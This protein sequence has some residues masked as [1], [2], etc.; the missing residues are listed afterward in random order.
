MIHFLHGIIGEPA[1]FAGVIRRL[2]IAPQQINNPRL[3]YLEQDVSGLVATVADGARAGGRQI[4]V[5]NS[6]GCQLALRLPFRVDHFVLT[7][8]PFDYNTGIVPLRRNGIGAWVDGLYQQKGNIEGEAAFL[9]SA[10][11]MVDAFMVDRRMIGKIREFRAEAQRFLASP[12]LQARSADVTFLIG[13]Q[14][15]STPP[16]DFANFVATTVPKAKL[17]VIE[18]CGHAVP[19]EH[20]D[21]V[22]RAITDVLAPRQRASRMA[23]LTSS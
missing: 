12:V 16:Q 9:Q 14:D 20:P 5:A 6:M 8:P 3:D 15:H 11:S 4:V 7:A 17:Q 18:A 23:R 22:A 10:C 13:A 21:Q 2:G 19:V 1:H